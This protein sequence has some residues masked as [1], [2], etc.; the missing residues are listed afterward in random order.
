MPD[1]TSA[2]KTAIAGGNSGVVKNGS[3]HW[4]EAAAGGVG[5]GAGLYLTKATHRQMMWGAGAYFLA[6]M[7]THAFYANDNAFDPGKGNTYAIKFCD[8]KKG[9]GDG[10]GIP[11][12]VWVGGT[13][14]TTG[15]TVVGKIDIQNITSDVAISTLACV[16]GLWY[17][18]AHMMQMLGG[19]AGGALGTQVLASYGYKYDDGML[20]GDTRPR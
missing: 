2:L 5:S 7:A 20:S 1:G 11:Y 9:A 16:A 8:A 18:G 19:A 4:R 6:N 15:N 10:T 3:F 12:K 14:P 13:T 17:S